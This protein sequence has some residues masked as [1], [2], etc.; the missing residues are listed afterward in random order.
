[1]P[2]LSDA[3]LLQLVASCPLLHTLGLAYSEARDRVRVKARA[4]AT[5]RV[6]VREGLVRFKVRVRM[7]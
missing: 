5:G 4:R 6:R 1:M 7:S 2:G 3:M